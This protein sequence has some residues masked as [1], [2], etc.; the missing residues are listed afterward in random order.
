MTLFSVIDEKTI[1]ESI[2]A[3]IDSGADGTLIPVSYLQA[4][5]APRVRKAR[6][7]GITGQSFWTDIYLVGIQI[8][9]IK[10]NGV[11]VIAGPTE[12]VILGRNVLNQLDIELRGPAET[13]EL[14]F[15]EPHAAGSVK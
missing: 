2:E 6:M 3:L 10:L 8:G 15:P 5:G 14:H 13:V 12:E 4:I 1:G 9:P 7:T 11:R